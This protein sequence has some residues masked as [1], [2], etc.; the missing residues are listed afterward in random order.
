MENTCRKCG[1]NLYGNKLKCPF[2]GH[3]ISGSRQPIERSNRTSSSQP[4]AP[5]S[6]NQYSY[7]RPARKKHTFGFV[8]IVILLVISFFVP[9]LGF[10]FFL[11]YNKEETNFATLALV[12]GI[13]GIINYLN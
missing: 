3:P 8:E 6:K 5:R 1:N 7:N 13:V 10:I 9:P 4:G 12:V 11:A 2:C